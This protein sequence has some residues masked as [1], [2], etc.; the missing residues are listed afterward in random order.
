MEKSHKYV[1]IIGLTFYAFFLLLNL[2]R[3]PVAWTDEAQLLD[4]ASKLVFEGSFYTNLQPFPTSKTTYATSLPVLQWV[5]IASLKLFGNSMYFVRLPLAIAGIICG[6]LLFLFGNKN[7][8]HGLLCLAL[9]LL[10]LNDMNVY[11]MIRS[12]RM[13]IFSAMFF[14]LALYWLSQKKY[15]LST[16]SISF[17]ILTHP[18][19]WA[20]GLVLFLYNWFNSQKISTKLYLPM[21]VLLPTI[22]WF[23]TI[24]FRFE[25]IQEQILGQGNYHAPDQKEGN[26]I[27]NLLWH[28]FWPYWKLQPYMILMHFLA[29]GLAI[30]TLFQGKTWSNKHLEIAFLSTELIMALKLATHHRYNV[31]LV[32]MILLI[33]AK[34]AQAYLLPKKKKYLSWALLICLPLILFPFLSRNAIGI[35]ERDARDPNAILSWLKVHVPLNKNTL[36]TGSDILHYFAME[37]KEITFFEKIYPQDIPYEKYAHYYILVNEKPHPDAIEIAKY[38]VEKSKLEQFLHRYVPTQNYRGLILYQLPNPKTLHEITAP[39]DFKI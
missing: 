33:L 20:A 12:G 38:Q 34:F 23:Y 3:I 16:V 27:T 21:L 7:A 31:L 14:L 15:I 1:F 9:P 2:D 11:E 6:I 25:A 37:K 22:F 5:Y 24:D 28:R 4:P 32:L 26:L 30:K 8:Y 19:A 13:E 39:Y 17:L 29:I 18:A 10:F 36:V 35:I